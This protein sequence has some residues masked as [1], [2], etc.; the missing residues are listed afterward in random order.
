MANIISYKPWDEVARFNPL[1]DPFEDLFRGFF[2]RPMGMEPWRGRAAPF[3]VEVTEN[4]N[5]YR[6]LAELPGMK[7]EDINVTIEGA[8]VTISA[9]TKQ[10]KEAKEGEKA[11][12]SERY[13]GKLQRAF[14]LEQ[15]VDQANAQARYAD[16]VLELTLPKSKAASTKR[17]A[18]H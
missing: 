15:E 7:K 16:G 14:T 5:A 9:E 18:V 4:E 6:V 1:E 2:V 8:T 17:I 3:K 10:E 13:Y 12:W 11:V